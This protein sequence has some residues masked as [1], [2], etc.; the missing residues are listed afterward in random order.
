MTRAEKAAERE[1]RLKAQLDAARRS[2]TQLEAQ[3]RARLRA[4]QHRR[5]IRV[6]IL[7]DEAGLLGWEDGTID[8]LFQVLARLRAATDPVKVLD[9][10]LAAEGFL[11]DVGGLHGVLPS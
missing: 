1:Q 2:R 11:I 7:A 5:H 8:Q 6:G 4:M 10:A 9:A 3:E